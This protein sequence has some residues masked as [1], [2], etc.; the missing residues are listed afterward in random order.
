MRRL[1]GFFIPD[2]LPD[3]P[4]ACDVGRASLAAGNYSGVMVVG[5]M[6]SPATSKGEHLRAPGPCPAHDAKA[7]KPD[8]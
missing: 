1:E 7:E 3:F 5:I 8:P 2:S 4:A 6:G